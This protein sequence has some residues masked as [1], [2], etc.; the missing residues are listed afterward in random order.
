[1]NSTDQRPAAEQPTQAE[2]VAELHRAAAADYGT[3]EEREQRR[4]D[5]R[6]ASGFARSHGNAAAGGI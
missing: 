5:A 1:M 2:R 4:T 3:S 6:L